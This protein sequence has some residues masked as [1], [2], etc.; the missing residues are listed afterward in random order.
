MSATCTPAQLADR[1]GVGVEKVVRWIKSGELRA[2]NLAASLTGRPRYRIPADAIAAFEAAR[3]VLP[4]PPA[5]KPRR[6]SRPE[7]IEFF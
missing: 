5:P 7:V 4:Q 6:K 3:S 1:Y 2:L